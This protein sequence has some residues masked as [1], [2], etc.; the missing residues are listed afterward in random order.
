MHSSG[1]RGSDF[2]I[3]WHG[4]ATTHAAFFAEHRATTRVGLFAPS[5][6]DGLGAAH[7]ALASVTAFYDRYRATGEPFFAYPD[8]F[9]FQRR[10]PVASFGSFDIWPDM[11]VEVAGPEHTLKAI[12]DRGIDVL[13]VPDEPVT[14]ERRF[15]R[16]AVERAHRNVRR[17]FAYG[18]TGE[19]PG[20]DLVIECDAEP[21]RSYCAHVARS[22][23]APLPD[24]MAAV[25]PA[26]TLRQHYRELGIDDALRR[27]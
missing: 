13:L 12:F 24:W 23:G 4:A 15:E 11:D 25:A 27:L 17:C 22:I 18:A 20:P 8:F 19:V 26:G 16:L 21:L 6:I 10:S 14:E 5:G 1:L 7:F 3:Q 2:R 9:T